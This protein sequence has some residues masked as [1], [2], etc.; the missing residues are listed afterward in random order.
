MGNPNNLQL[1]MD[2]NERRSNLQHEVGDIIAD[3]LTMRMSDG[4][5]WII[6][7]DSV[8]ARFGGQY[9]NMSDQQITINAA[10]PI[11]YSDLDHDWVYSWVFTQTEFSD[12]KKTSSYFH[13][14]YRIING[15]IRM[16]YQFK[17]MPP[18]D[19]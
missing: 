16:V 17:R 3:T 6:P 11:Y 1:I 2:W 4:T 12:G 18:I 13:E 8:I 15:K 14:D 19:N 7:R 10:I 9:E 5:E